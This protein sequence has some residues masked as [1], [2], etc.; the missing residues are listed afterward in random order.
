[1]VNVDKTVAT[2]TNI[3]REIAW[4]EELAE[5]NKAAVN[6]NLV[7]KL[8]DALKPESTYWL[9][10]S[11]V[12]QTGDTDL[13][14]FCRVIGEVEFMEQQDMD[15][16]V[17]PNYYAQRWDE[18]VRTGFVLTECFSTIC[19][20]GEYGDTHTTRLTM[21]LTQEQWEQARA[22]GW[23]H[24]NEDGL[25]VTG[26]TMWTKLLSVDWEGLHDSSYGE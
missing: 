16:D 25:T 12:A 10:A 22:D 1:M 26:K 15:E 4:L 13:L 19:P 5:I 17:P 3:I 23:N 8:Q 11:V 21:Q 18:Q 20:A 9:N 14:I 24:K 7:G 6:A 2:N